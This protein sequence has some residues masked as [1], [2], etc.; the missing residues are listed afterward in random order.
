LGNM[1]HTL[2]IINV[3]KFCNLITDLHCKKNDQVALTKTSQFHTISAGREREKIENRKTKIE[4][5]KTKSTKDA[6][7]CNNN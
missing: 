7:T 6:N 2:F 1:C 4:N 5:R 3:K